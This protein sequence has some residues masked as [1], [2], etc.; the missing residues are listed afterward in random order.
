LPGILSLLVGR[1]LCAR[2]RV[3]SVIGTGGMGAVCRAYDEKLER[4]VAVKVMTAVVKDDEEQERLRGRFYREARAA[5]RLR[6]PHVVT[7]HDFGTDEALGIDF[8]VMEFLDGEDL[9][10]RLR[11][12]GGPLPIPEAME[13][14][15][16]SAMGLAAG[17]RAGMVHRDVKPGNIYL[18]AEPGGWEVKLLDFGI[19]LV[20]A[21]DGEGESGGDT[22]TRF[23]VAGSPHTPRYASPEQLRGE[24]RLTPASD[25]YSLAL[26]GVEMLG[27]R[28]PDGLNADPDDRAAARAVKRLVAERSEV[29]MKLAAV[30]R[31][32]L[33]LDPAAR[34]PDAG[35]LLEALAEAEA[36]TTGPSSLT[37]LPGWTSLGAS[38][39]PPAAAPLAD[40]G[41]TA[42][43]PRPL[44]EPLPSAAWAPPPGPPPA[45]SPAAAPPAAAPGA[46]PDTDEDVGSRPDDAAR[47][48][49]LLIAGLFAAAALLIVFLILVLPRPDPTRPDGG[50]D[51]L[52]PVTDPF[53]PAPGGDEVAREEAERVTSQHGAE[54][55]ETLWVVVLAS[56]DAPRLSRAREM[57]ERLRERGYDVGLANNLVYPELRDGYVAVVA[58]PY[59]Q[60][61]AEA[62][63]LRL[64]P[65]ASDAFVMRVTLR[66]P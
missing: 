9:A 12:Y 19:A 52:P 36:A 14:L 37:G 58:G 3:E 21:A 16:E 7:V 41:G 64:L 25:V 18:V 38:S 66:V 8:L 56:F 6:H 65:L 53:E 50:L 26:T 20:A 27:G 48:R 63:R 60:G 29:S 51:P 17:H 30:L 43:A 34:Y 46:A 11:R 2:Y 47:R 4:R 33:R 45:A 55:G 22:M 54:A 62:E 24:A 40:D 15:R 28:Y 13:I 5:A 59:G 49:R 31:R 57:V 23:T 35:A 61:Q 39:V 10:A 1:T 32:S 42:F 44:Q